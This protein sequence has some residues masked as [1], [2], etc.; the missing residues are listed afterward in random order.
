MGIHKRER[1]AFVACCSASANMVEYS[2][3]AAL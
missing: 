3:A 1:N 2:V